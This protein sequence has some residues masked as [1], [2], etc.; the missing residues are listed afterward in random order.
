MRK[1][2]AAMV[3]DDEALIRFDLAQPLGEAGHKTFFALGAR[4]DISV[5]A[6]GASEATLAQKHQ[7]PDAAWSV[8]RTETVMPWKAS[9][10]PTKLPAT[11]TAC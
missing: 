8:T 6:V 11:G 3:V 4:R 7:K 1:Q 5:A 9:V 2:T 10:I